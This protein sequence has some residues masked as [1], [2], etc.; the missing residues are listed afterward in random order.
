[1]IMIEV[2]RSEDVQIRLALLEKS[3][4]DEARERQYEVDEL[5]AE[6]KDLN[7]RLSY[8]EKAKLKWGGFLIGITLLRGSAII[9]FNKVREKFISFLFGAE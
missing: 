7:E 8:L 3:Q 5:K 6:I 2:T 9:G 1:M 4:Q